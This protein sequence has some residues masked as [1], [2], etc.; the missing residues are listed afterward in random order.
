MGAE[1]K[2]KSNAR[3]SFRETRLVGLLKR[4]KEKDLVYDRGVTLGAVF[5]AGGNSREWPL[6]YFVSSGFR[7]VSMVI[8]QPAMFGT[9]RRPNKST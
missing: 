7:A 8:W 5:E 1:K 6:C 9:L 3:L 2:K 4:S